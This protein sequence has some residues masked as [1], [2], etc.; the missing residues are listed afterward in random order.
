MRNKRTKWKNQYEIIEGNSKFHES[1]RNI[2]V[3]DTFFSKLQC[4]QEVP[5]KELV[6]N[7]HKN[8][9][10][11]WFIDELGVILELHGEQ[12]YR[13]V[14]FGNHSYG[15]AKE[16]FHNIRYRDNLKKTALI[17]A[18]YQYREISYKDKIKINAE[19]LK[20]ILI[21]GE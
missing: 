15:E 13:I 14:N 18:G 17:Q 11:D 2:F 4:F 19:Y 8:H 20:R 9:Y 1:V 3:S 7:Y 21:Y 5:I 16:N 12:H 6:P 10:L